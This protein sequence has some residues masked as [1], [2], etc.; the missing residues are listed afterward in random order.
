MTDP[1]NRIEKIEG[2]GGFP[3]DGLPLLERI[4]VEVFRGHRGYY[5]DTPDEEP[6][7]TDLV[8]NTGRIFLAKRIG[9]DNTVASAMTYMM[10]GTGSTAPTLTD[11][12]LPGEIKRKTLAV[13]S[14]TQNNLYTAV[15]T[16]G[17]F[18]DSIQSIAITEAGV[19]NHASSGN[20]TMYQRITFAQEVLANSDI[21]RITME[22]L[23]GS[24]SI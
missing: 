3:Q 21:L 24:N 2:G 12:T 15:G 7:V 20:G 11:T 1:K 4:K 9:G 18:A 17:G 10:V 13:N 5:L 22:T 19:V 23:V 6:C 16:F 14:A 8:V